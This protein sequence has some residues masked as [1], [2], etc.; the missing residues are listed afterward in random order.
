MRLIDRA[1]KQGTKLT[2]DSFRTLLEED[3]DKYNPVIESGED[4]DFG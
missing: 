1:K 3:F 4:K 2:D